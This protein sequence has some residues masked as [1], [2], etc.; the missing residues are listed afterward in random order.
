MTMS[1]PNSAAA[2]ASRSSRSTIVSRRNIVIPA[3]FDDAMAAFAWAAETYDV[4]HRARAAIPPAAISPPP[5]ATRR[6][7]RTRTPVGQVLI[8]PGLGGD[9]TGR[10][11]SRPCRGADADGARPRILPGCPHRR[12]PAHGHADALSA[13]RPRLFRP[14]ADGAHHRRS[15]TRCR[16]TARPIATA[17]RPRAARRSGMRSRGWCTAICARAIP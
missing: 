7:A 11:L 15:A 17:S 6:A 13:C 4:A 12:C 8:Y 5:S 16:R 14:A 1:A 9:R 10:V 2:P 3:A